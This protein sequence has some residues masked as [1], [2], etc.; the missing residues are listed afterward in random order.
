MNFF[1]LSFGRALPRL[2]KKRWKF[3]SFPIAKF[4]VIATGSCMVMYIQIADV[5]AI[6]AS[7]LMQPA[8]QR[9]LGVDTLRELFENVESR[10]IV[11]VL[12]IH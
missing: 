5:N 1:L 2:S 11:A 7:V 3:A 4:V 6:T 8:R 9:Y 12:K 10:N